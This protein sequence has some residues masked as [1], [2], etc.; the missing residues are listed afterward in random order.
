MG[1][2]EHVCFFSHLGWHKGSKGI[3]FACIEDVRKGLYVGNRVAVTD[4]FNIV[5]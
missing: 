2:K 4:D 1:G 5:T 3:R